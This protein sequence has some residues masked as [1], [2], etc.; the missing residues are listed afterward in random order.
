M[1]LKLDIF[2]MPTIPAT[3][4]E[5][6]RER[7]IGRST[8]RYQMMLDA[9]RQLALMCEEMG[10]DAFSTT[11]HHFHTEGGEMMPS[12]LILFADLAART[13]NLQFIPLSLGATANNPLRIAEDVALLDQMSRGRVSVAL[14]RSY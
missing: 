4:E 13:R 8:E 6:A 5:R 3:L 14:A 10:V 7:P 2:A 12:P 9:L 11:E 1:G